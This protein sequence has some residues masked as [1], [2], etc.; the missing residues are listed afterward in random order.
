[1]RKEAGARTETV[2]QLELPGLPGEEGADGEQNDG[3]DE[4]AATQR[5]RHARSRRALEARPR[6]VGGSTCPP[7]PAVAAGFGPDDR[8]PEGRCRAVMPP[9]A[10]SG[11]A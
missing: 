1:E 4:P 10:Y 2:E 5:R 9:R 11:D 6:I 3:G 8:A 7:A